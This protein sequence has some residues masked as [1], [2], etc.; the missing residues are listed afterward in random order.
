MMAIMGRTNSKNAVML[1]KYETR[2]KKI[3]VIAI[4][5]MRVKIKP[6]MFFSNLKLCSS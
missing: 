1:K 2:E 3:D 4:A 5:A 6:I